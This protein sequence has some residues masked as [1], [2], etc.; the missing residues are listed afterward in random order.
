MRRLRRLR[1]PVWGLVALA[2][3][4]IPA[5]AAG[6]DPGPGR[7][8][9]VMGEVRISGNPATSYEEKSD[10]AWNSSTGQYLVVWSDGRSD[11]AGRGED[12]YA[13]LVG[14]DGQPIGGEKLISGPSALGDDRCPAVAWG[15]TAGQYLV[16][17]QDGRNASWDIYGRRVGA[18]GK[19]FGA[20]F[21]ISSSSSNDLCGDVA[22][23][24]TA[25]Q[26]LVVWE[27][28]RT[29]SRGADV[30]G[31]LVGA[32]GKPVGTADFLTSG[33]GAIADDFAPA[34]AWG[35]TTKQYLVVW[36]DYRGYDATG[37][38]IYGRR[39]TAAGA[40]TGGDF[41]ISG[42]SAVKNE[43]APAV[44]WSA[45][46]NQFLVVWEDWRRP[47]GRGVEIYAQRVK[48]NGALA[49]GEKRISGSG[50]TSDENTPAVAWSATSMQY[51]VT[52]QDWRNYYVP[53]YADIFGR[54]VGDDGLPAGN[55]FRVCG[56]KALMNDYDPA[57]AWNAL[58]NQFL[59][60]WTDARSYS[61]RSFDIYGRS[62]AG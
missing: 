60:V 4:L 8:T 61:S 25:N 55:D 38:D 5:A 56:N 19:P 43:Y 27:D 58:S 26:F 15:A 35:S 40:P 36:S 50:A 62:V 39:V 54:K 51:L 12:I 21:K 11:A 3:L 53:R 49:G 13:R 24:S 41:R 7:A 17:W 22:W 47:P 20:D 29:Y 9:P 42:A 44:A 52:W 23:G 18:D 59:V 57:A 10:V 6:A 28:Y 32:N 16:I 30:Y 37:A 2:V 33:A 1:R 46:M 14:A 31:R 45:T 34:V 48:A